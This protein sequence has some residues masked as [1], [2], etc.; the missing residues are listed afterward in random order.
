LPVWEKR[1]LVV[2]VVATGVSVVGYPLMVGRI[3]AE[4]VQAGV[5]LMFL[6]L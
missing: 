5:F 1:V 2:M 6:P 4:V 3:G